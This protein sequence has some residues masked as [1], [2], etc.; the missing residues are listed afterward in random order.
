MC[1]SWSQLITVRHPATLNAAAADASPFLS[2]LLL[3]SVSKDQVK[4]KRPVCG[5]E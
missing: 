4:K 1:M 3:A 2:I 5:V